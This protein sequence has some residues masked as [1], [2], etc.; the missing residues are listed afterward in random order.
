MENESKLGASEIYVIHEPRAVDAGR[1]AGWLIDGFGYFRRATGQWLAV[2]IVGFMIIIGVGFIPVVGLLSGI[3]APV[4]SAGLLLG[5]KDLEE[6]K[7][8]TVQHLFAG[9]R[10]KLAPLVLSGVLVSCLS[11]VI[12]MVI[13]GPR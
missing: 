8:L 4:W 12:V 11:M 7:P 2:C 5:C 6:G 10:D 1:G 13:L 9:F 3:L